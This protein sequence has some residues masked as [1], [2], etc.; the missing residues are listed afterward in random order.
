[1]NPAGIAHYQAE[2]ARDL[3][4][5]PGSQLAWLR[6]ARQAALEH[7]VRTGFP[8]RHLED[9]KYTSVAAIESGDFATRPATQAQVP[10]GTLQ[11]LALPGALT[12][13]F[14]DGRQVAGPDRSTLPA[15]LKLLSLAEALA[16]GGD[17]LQPLLGQSPADNSFAALNLAFLSDGACVLLEP[18]AVVEAPIQLLFLASE[19]GLGTHSR[20]LVRAGPG[21]SALIIEQHVGLAEARYFTNCITDI[22]LEAGARINHCKLQQESRE[23]CHIAAIHA[24]LGSDSQFGSGSFAFG[25]GLVRVDIDVALEEEGAVC[26][27]DGLYLA[28]GRR[29]IDHH[30][31]IDHAS[32]CC[33]SRELYK[34]VLGDTARA[35]FNG[36]VIVRPGA[37]RSDAFQINRNLLLSGQ[38]EV[39]TKP[40]LEIFADDVK[41]GH[42]ATVGQLDPEQVFY[43]RSRGLD[44]GAANS[45]LTRAFAAEISERVAHAELR[46]RLDILLERYLP[47]AQGNPP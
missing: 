22:Q 9:W 38:A 8:D 25:G 42:G 2:F 36:K 31:R 5:L 33:T 34:G 32:P 19:P 20:T 45:L 10:A 46:Q 41:C 27:L 26:T 29:H 44:E 30:T 12:L 15:G 7:F 6:E 21:S 16:H 43:L 24:R 39:D 40:Q 11:E 28:D 3:E 18:D 13:V 37:Q 17:R 14:V 47:L 35:V 23:A 4:V 1:M